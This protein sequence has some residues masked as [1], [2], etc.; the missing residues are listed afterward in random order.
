[1]GPTTTLSA[2]RAQMQKRRSVVRA[3]HC[4][5]KTPS[6]FFS[7]VPYMSPASPVFEYKSVP[8]HNNMS[9]YD[10]S[11]GSYPSDNGLAVSAAKFHFLHEKE[12]LIAMENEKSQVGLHRSIVI[13]LYSQMHLYKRLCSSNCRSV[14]PHGAKI[15]EKRRVITCL[16]H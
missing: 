8:G 5:V 15:A 1:M 3:P 12:K 16:I 11:Y 13:N 2:R 6:V 4:E 10:H 9:G 14:R 7:Q